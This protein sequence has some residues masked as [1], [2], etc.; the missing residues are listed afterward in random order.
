MV[1]GPSLTSPNRHVRG[2]L[3]ARHRCALRRDFVA[4]AGVQRVRKLRR[5]RADE[6]R[7]IALAHVGAQG[8]LA[9]HEHA[10]A[11]VQDRAVHLAGVVLEDPQ[12]RDL[13]GEEGGFAL[14]VAVLDAEQHEEA[15]ADR[16]DH[17]V[18]DGDARLAHPLHQR[19]HRS[20]SVWSTLIRGAP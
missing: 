11:H 17:P 7:P 13:A 19:F 10:A 18:A 1:T 15:A 12:V 5:R 2:E 20:T 8:E 9:D 6:A 14:A 16:S 4:E 3:A